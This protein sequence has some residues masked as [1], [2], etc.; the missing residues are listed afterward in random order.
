MKVVLKGCPR[1]NGDLVPDR[2]DL[3]GQDMVCVQCGYE[4]PMV[5]VRRNSPTL[6]NTSTTTASRPAAMTATMPQRK[7]A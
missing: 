4:A 6:V 7:V 5:L 2:W 3:D 1:C